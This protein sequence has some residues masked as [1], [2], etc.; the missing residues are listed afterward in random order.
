M[1]EY[2]SHVALLAVLV[3]AFRDETS[4][5]KPYNVWVKGCLFHAVRLIVPLFTVGVAMSLSRDPDLC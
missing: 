3:R 2:F 5:I 4:P 1:L